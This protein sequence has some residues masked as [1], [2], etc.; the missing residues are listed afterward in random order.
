M[1]WTQET[2]TNVMTN[3]LTEALSKFRLEV[4]FTKDAVLWVNKN[5]SSSAQI[6]WR[7]Q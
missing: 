1:I 7:L 6:Y 4:I 3:G 5:S 2:I